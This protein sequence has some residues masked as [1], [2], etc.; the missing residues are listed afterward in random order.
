MTPHDERALFQA[1]M[2]VSRETMAHLDQLEQLLRKWNPAIN[3]VAQ[4]SIAALWS[5]HYLDSAQVFSIASPTTGVWADLGSGGGFPGL[6]VAILAHE[7]APELQVILVEADRR[8]A[9][10]LATL[11]RECALRAQIIAER[12]ESTPPLAAQFLSA[13]AL[14]PLP[15]LLDYAERHLKEGGM[16][17]FSKGSNW[18]DEVSE[19]RRLWRFEATA[20]PSKTDE[21]AAILELR[22]IARA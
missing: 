20:H 9:A 13:R 17:M 12:I 19:A 8:K 22:G 2:G 18:R 14:A 10:F 6:V 7:R 15:K 1:Q 21:N 11:V 4:S 5:R 16:A 3:L